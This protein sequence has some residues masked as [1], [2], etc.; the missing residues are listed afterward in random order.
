MDCWGFFENKM[1]NNLK[2][3]SRVVLIHNPVW[4]GKIININKY[5]IEPYTI[6]WINLKTN[7]KIV[8]YYV[9]TFI[10][11]IGTVE[12]PEYLKIFNEI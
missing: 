7:E 4:I 8:M 2:I 6:D 10:K 12:C 11:L 5:H 3:G 1:N 9:S